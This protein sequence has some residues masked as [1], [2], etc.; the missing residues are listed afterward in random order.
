MAYV[1]VSY[2]LF[3]ITLTVISAA[4]SWR[5]YLGTRQERTFRGPEEHHVLLQNKNEK[6]VEMPPYVTSAQSAREDAHSYRLGRE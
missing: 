2:F 1:Y 3:H 4:F 5:Q 6:D